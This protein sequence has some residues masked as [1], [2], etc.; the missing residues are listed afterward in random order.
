MA[1]CPVCNNVIIIREFGGEL[2]EYRGGG[3]GFCKCRGAR[4]FLKDDPNALNKFLKP[5]EEI[6][7]KEAEK[8]REEELRR[9]EWDREREERK[10]QFLKQNL[11]REHRIEEE[12]KNKQISQNNEI[13]KKILALGYNGLFNESNSPF[14][15]FY[16]LEK[17]LAKT[18][19]KKKLIEELLQIN[20][21]IN[22]SKSS[23]SDNKKIDRFSRLELMKCDDSTITSVKNFLYKKLEFWKKFGKNTKFLEELNTY[24][25]QNLNNFTSVGIDAQTKLMSESMNENTKYVEK[26][27][28]LTDDINIKDYPSSRLQI[29][30]ILI[31]DN[32][33]LDKI[34]SLI[35]EKKPTIEQIV[36]DT[37]L[38]ELV[39]Q[40]K[41]KYSAGVYMGTTDLVSFVNEQAEELKEEN[42]KESQYWNDYKKQTRYDDYKF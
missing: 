26:T 18:R 9:L 30:N 39:S 35:K 2:V 22:P 25:I 11:E 21:V 7:Q 28:F 17:I 12:R 34:L 4:Q 8:E 19:E 36:V 33:T 37:V 31:K 32:C 16:E 10:L 15:D 1:N 41:V 27:A 3:N 6:K 13:K 20:N 40:K 29:A 38:V 24:Q 42:R 5:L 23:N 14:A